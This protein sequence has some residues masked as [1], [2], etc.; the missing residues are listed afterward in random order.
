VF[1]D[2]LIAAH[3]GLSDT[4]STLLPGIVVPRARTSS[5]ANHICS[6]AY[7]MLQA[8]SQMHTSICRSCR[9]LAVVDV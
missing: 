3:E 1:V 8:G 6:C 2:E 4:N 7:D 5:F 9:D